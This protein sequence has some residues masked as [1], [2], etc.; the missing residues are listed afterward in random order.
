MAELYQLN[1]IKKANSH[2]ERA[3]EIRKRKRE[4]PSDGPKTQ[5]IVAT[6]S[7]YV[8]KGMTEW[9][10]RW[11]SNNF[12][13]SQNTKPANLDLFLK[14]DA[15]LTAEEV[16]QDVLIGFWHVAREYKKVA[17]A[18]AKKAARDGHL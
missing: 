4:A 12:R 9:L 16:A 7:E 6:D 11:K 14:L 5:W 2:T 8:V 3:K 18:L 13:T 10:P 17:D 15:A 1:E